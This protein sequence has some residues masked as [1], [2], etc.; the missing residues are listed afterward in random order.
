[1]RPVS[2]L[3]VRLERLAEDSGR[4]ISLA[5]WLEFG[6]VSTFTNEVAVL[7]AAFAKSSL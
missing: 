6:C 5:G 7:P 4:Q 3:R 1:M 2:G